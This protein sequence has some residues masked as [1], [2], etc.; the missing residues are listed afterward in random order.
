MCSCNAN[1]LIDLDSPVETVSLL[2]TLIW[3][4]N[5]WNKRQKGKSLACPLIECK[6]MLLNKAKA[7]ETSKNAP[8]NALRVS[9]R[10]P[11]QEKMLISLAHRSFDRHDGFEWDLFA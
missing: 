4:K 9:N 10:A 6:G 8:P 3:K 1:Y 11:C 7:L 5:N 2:H